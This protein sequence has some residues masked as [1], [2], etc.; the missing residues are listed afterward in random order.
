V[1][2]DLLWHLDEAEVDAM[3][4]NKLDE[5]EEADGEHAKQVGP[6]L[7]GELLS[8]SHNEPLTIEVFNRRGGGFGHVYLLANER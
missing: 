6:G 7:A 3:I 5:I 1:Y 2:V 4:V 8:A